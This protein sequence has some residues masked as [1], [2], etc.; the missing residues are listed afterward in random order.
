MKLKLNQTRTYHI[1]GFRKRA[2]CLCFRD[3]SLRE[4]LLVSSSNCS[5]KW[6]VPGGGIE[7]GEDSKAAAVREVD[8]EAGVEGNLIS[9]LGSFDNKDRRTRTH[10]YILIVERLKDNYLEARTIGRCRKW[11][12]IQEACEKLALHKPVQKEYLRNFILQC[13][14]LSCGAINVEKDDLK[15]PILCLNA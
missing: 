4:V 7:P 11:F 14:S 12:S 9:L 2:A 3:R 15:K 13:T 6:I 8:E 10:V 1:D 5:Q